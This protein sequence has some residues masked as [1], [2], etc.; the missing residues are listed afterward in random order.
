MEEH[1]R[2]TAERSAAFA[3]AFGEAEAGRALGLAH[4]IGKCS[5]EFQRR[6]AGGRL[7]DHATAGA[8]ECARRDALWAACCVAGHH[9]GLPDVGNLR[10]DR[11]DAPTLIGRLRRAMAPGGIPDYTVPLSLSVPPPDPK[12]EADALARAFYIRMLYSCLV[13][14]DFLDTEAFMEHG[15][16]RRGGY[17]PLSVLLDRLE[18]AIAPW[19]PPENELNARRCVILRRCIDG[20]AGE[21]GLYTLTVPTGGGKTVASLA[22]ALRHA[23]RHGMDR[24]IYVIPYTSIIEQNAAVFRRILGENNV[25]EHHSGVLFDAAERGDTDQYRW[26]LATENWDAPVIVTTAVQ[27][28]ES[29]YASRPSQCRK[30]HSIANS[31]VIFDEAQMLPTGHLRPCV[32]AIAQLVRHFSATAVLCTATQPVLNDLFAAYAPGLPIRELCPGTEDL[33][34]AFRRVTFQHAGTLDAETLAGRL[35]ALDQV[36]CVVNTRRAAREVY[37]L[38]PQEGSFHLS[39]LMYPAHRRAVLRT[40][41]ER[42]QAGL[43]CRVVSTSLVEAGVDVDF[44]AVYREMAG[45][46]SI[47]QAAGRCNREGRR[48]VEESVV[49]VFA[50]VSATPE[51]LRL[52]IQAA[53]EALGQGADIASPETVRRYFAVYRALAGDELDK[54]GQIRALTE[55]IDGCDLPFRTAAERFH[56]L[57]DASRTVYIPEGEGAELADRLRQGERSRDLFRRLGQY[58]VSVYEGH[59]QALLAS[60]AVEPLDEGGGVLRQA[61]LYSRE[62]GLPLRA[63]PGQGLY[64]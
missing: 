21:K 16:V 42:L 36:L 5:A 41:R 7:V 18:R 49:T 60:G 51:L 30:L 39:T 25:V 61:E 46:D 56:F 3:A 52:P 45:L 22:F 2:G 54:S 32:A 14:A 34:R 4:D 44:P 55:G 8:L 35:A 13:D 28:F 31:V 38:L 62:T 47:L 11:E 37:G 29:L 50:G 59:Y 23:V 63:E 40:I 12:W 24:V 33:Y 64:I 53:R 17:E 43:P 26:A 15:R 27:F 6:L 19:W 57:D 48:T 58:G 10:V 1:L 9:G 20:A